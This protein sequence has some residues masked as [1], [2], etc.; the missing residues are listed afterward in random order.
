MSL[1]L[2]STWMP[3][4]THR[5]TRFKLHPWFSETALL[6]HVPEAK[7][8]ANLSSFLPASKLWTPL[9]ESLEQWHPV[10]GCEEKRLGRCDA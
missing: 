7:N 1:L 9:P 5:T 2:P 6:K 4:Q 10:G 8:T 3:Q